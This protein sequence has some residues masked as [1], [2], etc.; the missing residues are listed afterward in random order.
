MNL[1]YL[2]IAIVT[3]KR[4][5]ALK[6]C[7]ESIAKQTHLPSSVLI[8]D[9]DRN[10]S[11]KHIFNKFKSKLPL[12]YIVEPIK[13]IPR[14]R[15]LALKNCQT[16]YLAFIDDDCRPSDNWISSALISIKNNPDHTFII[17]KSQ[18]SNPDQK[19]AKLNY[20]LYLNWFKSHIST[21]TNVF[22]SVAL[23]TKNIILNIRKMPNLMFDNQFSVLED[24]DFG[25]SLKQKNLTGH[26]DPSLIIHHPEPTSIIKTFKRNYFRGLHKFLLE[27]KWGNFDNYQPKDPKMLLVE[28]LKNQPS[29]L[30]PAL[31]SYSFDLGYLHAKY[32]PQK[33]QLITIVNSLDHTANEERARAIYCFLQKNHYSTLL[34][35]AQAE[36]DH[37]VNRPSG[38]L[39]YPLYFSLY[40]LC[41]SLKYR[42]K[43]P[44]DNYLTYLK[45][46]LRGQI[47]AHYLKTT[48]TKIAIIQHPEDLWTILSSPCPTIYDSPTVYSQEVGL[49]PVS[50]WLKNKLIN[51]EKLAFRKARFVCFHWYGYL[52]HAL[53]CHLPL[54]N[55]F[56]LNWGCSEANPGKPTQN[57]IVYL[58]NLSSPWIDLQLL[59]DLLHLSPLP[60][61]IY[62][63]EKKPPLPTL[64]F[65]KNLNSINT[66]RFGLIAPINNPHRNH[67]LSAK[68]LLYLSFGLPVL[69]PEWLYDPLLAPATIYYRQ[70]NFKKTII[71]YSQTKLWRQ[72]HLAA[73]KL[74]RKLSWDKTLLPL[75]G[76][77]NYLL[78]L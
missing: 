7:L 53:D 66:Y 55:Y 36:F 47:S 40:R 6:K 20:Q 60:I 73:L 45:F 37:T 29:H 32:H 57:K 69:S 34:F 18:L 65:L 59:T 63:Y 27:Q 13:G 3:R 17:G 70:D 50:S 49:L 43:L 23:D 14:A 16:H 44:T 30:L 51:A 78:E 28:I 77:I 22:D 21:K 48:K 31:F 41:R 19:I 39:Q 68:H 15:N 12:N 52:Q 35:D 74:S 2:T 75:L 46:R 56:I 26:Y 76:K 10:S 62:S 4:P 64:G 8:I 25:L 38:F 9:N 33:P 42:F 71:K 24:I 11:A 5:R 72:K 54:K 1:G 61:D 67:G 58:G